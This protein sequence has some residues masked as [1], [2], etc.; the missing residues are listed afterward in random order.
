MKKVKITTPE[1]IDIEV[2][3]AEALSRCC[4]TMI[5][6]LIQILVGFIVGWG[7]V[8]VLFEVENTR[9]EVYSGWIV[10]GLIIIETIIIFG[11]YVICEITMS[12]RT[13][14][15]KVLHLR[16]IKNNGGTVTAKEA[17]LRNL[18][19][20]LLDNFGI[21]VLMMLFQ[22][23]NKRVGDLVAGTM[24]IIEE[25]N[26][27]PIPLEQMIAVNEEV[28]QYL[29][30]EE[31]NLLRE[32]FERKRTMSYYEPLREEMRGH[33]KKKFQEAGIYEEN[34]DFINAI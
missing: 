33:F 27:R 25:K 22:K 17:I 18:F 4:A 19:K 14:G 23:K 30:K 34:Q 32:Y 9:I 2:V 16:T 15:K 29:T 5:D 28:K 20:V 1:N 31:Y 7:F 11:Y 3:L 10:A 24:V 26:E 13:I 21:G 6:V 8:A 12:G